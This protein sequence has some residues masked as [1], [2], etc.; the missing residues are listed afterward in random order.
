MR[1]VKEI[2][3]ILGVEPSVAYGLLHFMREKGFIIE[4]KE[5][6]V[7]GRKGKTA[8]TYSFDHTSIEQLSKHLSV[9]VELDRKD[10]ADRAKLAAPINPAP[11]ATA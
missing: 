3:R 4:G 2:A 1:T 5:K 7:A 10:F 6:R 8:A 9:L 11:E